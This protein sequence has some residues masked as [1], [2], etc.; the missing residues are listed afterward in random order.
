MFKIFN[1]SKQSYNHSTI[2]TI[3][4]LG[5]IRLIGSYYKSLTPE[6]E[7]VPGDLISE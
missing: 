3:D 4:D 1:L 5:V 7:Q 6:F 2:F